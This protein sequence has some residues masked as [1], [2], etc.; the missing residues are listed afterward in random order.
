[1]F[2]SVVLFA[3]WV[4]VLL[5]F[6]N[7]RQRPQPHN[8]S[9]KSRDIQPTAPSR[10]GTRLEVVEQGPGEVAADLGKVELK[11]EK[12]EERKRGEERNKETSKGTKKGRNKET[13]KNK[14]TKKQRKKLR[15][16]ERN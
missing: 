3:W 4:A 7:K 6:G 8:N 1:M 14:E 2:V 15:N 12:N 13:M 16:K 9:N 5:R 10:L 11:R